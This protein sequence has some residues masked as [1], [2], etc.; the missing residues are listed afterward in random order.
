MK[1]LSSVVAQ[2]KS[3]GF[4]AYLVEPGADDK[5]YRVRVGT[6]ETRANVFKAMQGHILGKAVYGGLF[7]RPQ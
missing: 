2:L 1:S 6:F 5:L 7:R 4:D 3:V